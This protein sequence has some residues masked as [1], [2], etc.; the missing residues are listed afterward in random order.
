MVVP[1]VFDVVD[2]G[3]DVEVV[4]TTLSDSVGTVAGFDVTGVMSFTTGAVAFGN[5]DTLIG[6]TIL[7]VTMTRSVASAEP[8]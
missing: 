1:L 4:L 3:S 8:A 7:L 6:S 2:S 5:H